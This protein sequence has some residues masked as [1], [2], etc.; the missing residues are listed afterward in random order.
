MLFGAITAVA[1]CV[2][3]SSLIRGYHYDMMDDAVANPAY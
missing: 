3:M 1:G 2:L